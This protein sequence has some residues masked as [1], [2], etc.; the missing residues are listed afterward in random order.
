MRFIPPGDF[1]RKNLQI[2]KH[3]GVH[4]DDVRGHE[5]A[6]SFEKNGFFLMKLDE[7]MQIEDFDRMDLITS[8]YLPQVA[9]CLKKRLGASR[10]QVHDYLVRKSH[11]TF[12]IST[13]KPYKWE[14]P[15]TLL[16]IVPESTLLDSTPEGTRQ[17]VQ[18]LNKDGSSLVK[19][20][21]QYVTVWKP[22]RG[23]VTR[24]PLMMG[25]TSTVD[26]DHDLEARDMVYYGNVVDTHLVYKSEAHRFMYLSDQQSSEAWVMLQSDSSGLTGTPHTAFPNPTASDADPGRESIEVRTL[27][28]YNE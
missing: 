2:T 20:R 28:Y 5:D 15:A 14:Q 12:P 19:M 11:S 3:D 26:A 18:D 13:G 10:V 9:E 23:P 8:V 21:Y 16:H 6:L 22:I 24:W 27:V 4:V 7:L 17:I 25:D 1:P